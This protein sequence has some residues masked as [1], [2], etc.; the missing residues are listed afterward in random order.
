M[1]SEYWGWNKAE[2]GFFSPRIITLRFSVPKTQASENSEFNAL[3]SFLTSSLL[4]KGIDVWEKL[5]LSHVCISASEGFFLGHTSLLLCV[6]RQNPQP[7]SC[8]VPTFLFIL[9]FSISD[10]PENSLLGQH[11]P[12]EAQMQHKK[13][14]PKKT[15]KQKVKI[16]ITSLKR[17]LKKK[18]THKADFFFFFKPKSIPRISAGGDNKFEI[19]APECLHFSPT[20][21]C[22]AN[23]SQHTVRSLSSCPVF[24][25]F[26][27]SPSILGKSC[28]ALPVGW[29]KQSSKIKHISISFANSV[30]LQHTPHH[31]HQCNTPPPKKKQNH[32]QGEKCNEH[33]AL[34]LL[35]LAKHAWK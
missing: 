15:P 5:L 11:A 7:Q 29:R 27:V 2:S 31:P 16:R 35:T 25:L 10:Q 20:Q 34:Y 33:Q 22:F 32:K 26:P 1:L 21:S 28:F 24:P 3:F 18:K 30:S 9:L 23:I 13:Q 14:P 12:W 19:T 4:P 8:A 17:P 6:S